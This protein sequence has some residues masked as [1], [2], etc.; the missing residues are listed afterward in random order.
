MHRLVLRSL[1]A[2]CLMTILGNGGVL[3]A[4]GNDD[5]RVGI[6]VSTVV[7]ASPSVGARVSDAMA[8]ALRETLKAELLAGQKAQALLP[9][10]AQSG[11][12]LGDSACL[13]S[14]GKAMG[15]DQLL[16]L[17]IVGVG[18]ELKIEATWVN[19]ATGETALRPGITS[20]DDTKA[21]LTAFRVHANALLPNV[22]LR[23]KP[24]V[25]ADP[26][27]QVD[28]QQTNDSPVVLTPQKAK[29]SSATS[30]LLIL[31]GGALMA[32][33]GGYFL[34]R[35]KRCNNSFECDNHHPTRN[36]IVDTAGVVGGLAFVAGLYLYLSRDEEP[37][38]TPAPIGFTLNSTSVGLSLGGSF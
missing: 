14:A 22:A 17:I 29:A 9:E 4:Q 33:S 2:L 6:A 37:E 28:P 15:V 21:L 30:R 36:A 32:G 35:Y 1:A 24:T 20:A 3:H 31:G 34:V 25:Q 13:V 7:N 11:T 23:Q 12:C 18:D 38:S 26:V 5:T 8:E 16:M 27:P 10:E 19:V